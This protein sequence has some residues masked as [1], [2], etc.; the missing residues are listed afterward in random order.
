M[1]SLRSIGVLAACASLAL[2][3]CGAEHPSGVAS[4]QSTTISRAALAHW[5][6]IKRR[7]TQGSARPG[8]RT[9]PAELQRRALVFLITADWL[10]AEA[11]AQGIEVSPSE[12]DT[13]YR[14]LLRGPMGQSFARSLRSRG[15]FR[16]DEL[17]LLRLQQ[18][19][20]KLQAKITAGH[21]SLW[22]ARRV[23]AFAAAYRRRWKRRTSC[24]PGYVIAE[25]RNGPPLPAG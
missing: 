19:S 16:T 1:P 20:N 25:C 3:G 15:I 5:T 17:L 9:S 21:D 18:L 12:V 24:E 7:E 14:E 23:A 4:V 6:E 22:A 13:T 11:S 2:C 8:S 10:Q